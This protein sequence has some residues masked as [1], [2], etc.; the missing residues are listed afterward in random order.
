MKEC[1]MLEEICKIHQLKIFS[2]NCRLSQTDKSKWDTAF[3]NKNLKGFGELEKIHIVGPVPFM[4][5][6]RDSL[7]ASDLNVAEK[8][9][10]P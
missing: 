2:Y 5:A 8:I 3:M 9:S 7:K 10:F 1:E 6:V 4:D